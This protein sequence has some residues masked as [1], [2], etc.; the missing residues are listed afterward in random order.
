MKQFLF[1][2]ALFACLYS[3]N[4]WAS[5][6]Q[7]VGAPCTTNGVTAA[8]N[9]S[10][11][12]VI[13]TLGTWVLSGT[14]LGTSSTAT[15][16]QRSG[17]AATGFFSAATG[18]VSISSAGLDV[19]D[20]A[21]TGLNLPGKLFSYRI[22]GVNAVWQ[23]NISFNTAIG[24]TALPATI[25]QSG[26]GTNG[27]YV[28]SLGYQS[29]NANTT[30]AYNTGIGAQTLLS[31]T[32]GAA[33]TAVG[34]QALL[35]NT[36]GSSNTAVGDQALFLNGAGI[37]NTAV[38][39]YALN[40][41]TTGG[42]NTSVG[43]QSLSSNTTGNQNTAFGAASLGTA[44]TG[45]LNTAMGYDALGTVTTGS[46]NTAIGYQVGDTT[47]TTGSSNI[48]IGTSSAVDTPAS[49][50]SHFLNIGN[51]IFATGMTGT[52]SSPAGSVGIGTATPQATLDVNG[53]VRLTL[54]SSAP[55]VCS[56]SNPGA[57]ALNHLAQICVCNG[58]AWNLD[59]TGAACS[60]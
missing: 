27:E 50:T 58:T 48:L 51:V 29:L 26:G 34:A 21:S 17:D 9:Q 44:T 15:N 56:T 60:W 53:F 14:T 40:V 3:F 35:S 32:T 16:P 36:T 38:G 13:C 7:A 8:P 54:N 12:I 46:S 49:G 22:N 59:R 37:Q 25:S 31:N 47:L 10:G 4:A 45:S 5:D 41:T 55:A 43:Y 20:F 24:D 33:N 30:G 11:Q 6:P 23:D 39:T 1:L 28:V 42:Q 18:T 52:L 57:I 2:A 19:G